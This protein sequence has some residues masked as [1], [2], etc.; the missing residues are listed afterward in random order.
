M[1]GARSLPHFLFTSSWRC[2]D[3]FTSEDAAADSGYGKGKV[4]LS[5]KKSRRLRGDRERWASIF[6]LTFGTTTT[7][8][9]SALRAGRL[10]PPR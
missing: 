8:E 7:A 10:Y 2:T 1:R 3:N 6:T 9:L 4:K 5:R